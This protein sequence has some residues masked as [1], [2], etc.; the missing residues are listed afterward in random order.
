VSRGLSPFPR[1]S[2]GEGEGAFGWTVESLNAIVGWMLAT[3]TTYPEYKQAVQK[4]VQQH[5]MLRNGRLHLA[6]Y[7]APPNRTSRDIYVFEVIDDFGAGRVDA[8][9]NLFAFA[10][11]STP[12]LPLPEGVRLWMI[13]TNPTELDHAIKG[14]WK[15]VGQLR[16][17]RSA[18][19]AVVI[20]A[21]TK[22]KKLWNKIG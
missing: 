18:G 13:L 10:Y 20:Y 12:G 21:D 15:R 17:A 14:N 8:D 4:L 11:G 16:K 3:I 5:R 7:L 19:K 6:V 9:K 2:G 22:G 1:H